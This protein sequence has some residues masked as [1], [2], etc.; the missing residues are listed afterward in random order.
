MK[1]AIFFILDEYADWE[2]AYLSSQL[3]QNKNWEVKTAS[4]KNEVTSI[5]G[6]KTLVD[7]QVKDITADIN[8]LVLIGGN[9]WSIENEQLRNLIAERLTNKKSVAAICVAV[10]YLAKNGLLTNFKHTGNAQ[11]LWKNYTKYVNKDDFEQKQVVRDH[12]LVTA[13]GTA[14]LEFT[15]QVLKMI[16]FSSDEQINKDV[17]LYKLGFYKYCSKY[18]N[19]FK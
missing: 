19:P 6:F 4:I 18:G 10:D 17:D 13:N 5:G 16:S 7:Y 14:P 8:L 9:S 15:K 3:N 2:G 1:K 11:Y 12:N